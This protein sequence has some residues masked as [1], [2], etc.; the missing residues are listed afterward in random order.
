MASIIP[1]YIGTYTSGGSAGIY[2][3]AL[4]PKTGVL[5][6]KDTA[7]GKNPSFLALTPD[8]QTL[9]AVWENG[10][11]DSEPG[12]ALAAYRVG[13]D[14]LT[15]LGARNVRGVAPCHVALSPGGRWAVT[16]NYGDGTHTVVFLAPDGSLD[17]VA[18]VTQNAGNPGPLPA[19]EDG[20]HAHSVYFSP[21]G[22]YLLACDLGV[23]RVIVYTFDDAAG[24]LREAAFLELPAGTGPRHFVWH[25]A[26]TSTAYVVG[27]HAN[28][29]T[30]LRFD[31]TSAT[32]AAF[33]V[34]STLPDPATRSFAADIH[35]SADGRF[36]YASN[37]GDDSLAVFATDGVTGSL[38]A[39][40]HAPCG[41]ANP[42]N[43]CLVPGT[44]FLLC[45]HQDSDTV[46]VFRVEADGMPREVEG[47]GISVPTPTCVLP[48]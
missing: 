24:T 28:T 20:P 18:G 48:G 22:A 21:D 42:R 6:V 35:I 27:E 1:I 5:S 33:E 41:G 38:S 19:Q 23:D 9:F 7:P 37:R 12:G 14:G 25:P 15:L 47:A 40:G 31:A 32:L 8:K 26:L 36:V 13:K 39:V 17:T 2:R 45:A 4:N 30:R 43:F 11:H 46:S 44:D 16:S 10:E 29:A 3:C 34:V